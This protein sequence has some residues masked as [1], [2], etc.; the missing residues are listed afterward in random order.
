MD[1]CDVMTRDIGI[2][3]TSGKVYYKLVSEVRRRGL[4]F[5]SLTPRE[6]IPFYVKVIITTESER[7]NIDFPEILIYDELKDPFQVVDEAV[8]MLRGKKDFREIIIGIDPGKRLGLAILGDGIILKKMELR[9]IDETIPEIIRILKET[10]AE[11]KTV[12]IGNGVK[13]EQK[14]LF[15]VLNKELPNN[16]IIES[17][18][19]DG[20][21]KNSKKDQKF[22]KDSIDVLSA[23][24]ISMRNGYELNRKQ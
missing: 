14:R 2:L 21:T 10:K 23:I 13:E 16:V 6:F 20:T 22:R 12:K 5:I 4:P 11:K 24:K 1:E 8:Q 19:E 7:I 18:E 17:V 15:K 9:N 3:T